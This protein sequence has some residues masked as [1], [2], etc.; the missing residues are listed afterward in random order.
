MVTKYKCVRYKTTKA[1]KR[2]A[3]FY[4]RGHG[5][6]T[7]MQRESIKKGI[8]PGKFGGE[9]TFSSFK[10]LEAE[11]K[12]QKRK[13]VPYATVVRRIVL[14]TKVLG[15]RD[16]KMVRLGEKGLAFAKKLYNR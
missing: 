1:G 8:T 16:P 12:R 10:A 15:K 2:C 5:K 13:G 4:P 9:G 14:P 11:I 7:A 6:L 3:D